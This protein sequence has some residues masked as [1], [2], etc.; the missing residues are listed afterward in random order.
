MDQ[1]ISKIPFGKMRF[2]KSKEEVREMI[3]QTLIH[4]LRPTIKQ[5]YV[6]E[7]EIFEI[8]IDSL[9]IKYAVKR[10]LFMFKIFLLR[11]EFYTS[12]NTLL[13]NARFWNQSI[14]QFPVS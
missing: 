5:K 3:L 9:L 11:L 10:K 1:K 6:E 14:I 4:D 13:I 2:Y 7:S 8:H 12:F